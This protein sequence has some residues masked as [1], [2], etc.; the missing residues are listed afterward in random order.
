MREYQS[1]L[2]VNLVERVRVGSGSTTEK[3]NEEN[4]ECEEEDLGCR[5]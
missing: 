5:G 2:G 3:Q 1:V 4:H